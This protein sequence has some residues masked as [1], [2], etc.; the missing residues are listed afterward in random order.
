[1]SGG[2][3]AGSTAESSILPDGSPAGARTPQSAPGRVPDA[4][5][6]RSGPRGHPR[7]TLPEIVDPGG[8][9]SVFAVFPRIVARDVHSHC[10]P[11]RALPSWA[12]TAWA[13]LTMGASS[14]SPP[15]W[16]THRR[17]SAR[18]AP[19]APDSAPP[20]GGICGFPGVS[21]GCSGPV[22]PSLRS[23]LP[24]NEDCHGGAVPFRE[25]GLRSSSCALACRAFPHIAG[26]ELRVSAKHSEA[27]RLGWVPWLAKRSGATTLRLHA[28]RGGLCFR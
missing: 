21:V 14:S 20:V 7:S 16:S 23:P 18:A 24:A 19:S 5:E 11:P 17:R 12:S 6:A 10:P 1:M 22:A 2:G 3:G 28:E 25:A 13:A 27:G 9:V 8:A 4:Q 26:G 15:N